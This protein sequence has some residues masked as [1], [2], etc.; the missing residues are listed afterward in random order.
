[1]FG[2]A[3]SV[4]D[5]AGSGMASSLIDL[6]GLDCVEDV[7]DL[8]SAVRVCSND[9]VKIVGFRDDV[10]YFE[11][12][13]SFFDSGVFDAAIVLSRH[14][15]SSGVPSLTVHSTGNPGPQALYG[16]RPFEIAYTRPSYSGSLLYYVWVLSREGYVSS[17]DFQVT[18]EATHHGPTGNRIPVVF[19]ELGSSEREWGVREAHDLWARAIDRFIDKGS[20]CGEL[21]IGFGGS[22]YPERFTRMTIEKGICFGHIIPRYALKNLTPDQVGSIVRR[23]VESSVEGV[24]RVYVEEKAAQSA[25]IKA[26]IGVLDDLGVG[27]VI[28]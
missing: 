14:R 6:Y 28:L 3:Y 23:V 22:H 20:I 10:I 2:F 16:G 15:A 5:V 9:T 18:Y 4:N 8:G 1:M 27:Y 25:K 11:F 13:D 17:I 7:R 12:L 24:D 19:V 21:A 26:I